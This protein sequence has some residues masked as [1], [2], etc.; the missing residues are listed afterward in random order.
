MGKKT[1]PSKTLTA[2]D[3]IRQ[4]KGNRFTAITVL[5]RL[6]KKSAPPNSRSQ[7]NIRWSVGL[8]L[9]S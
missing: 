3:A 9:K 6:T 5:I 1:T 7:V 8:V 4:Q 2:S